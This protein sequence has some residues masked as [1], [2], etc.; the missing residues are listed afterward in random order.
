MVHIHKVSSARTR[1]WADGP[2]I[3]R[4]VHNSIDRTTQAIA[5]KEAA[6]SS[7]AV[8]MCGLFR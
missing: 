8:V 7:A 1:S 5:K 2:I 4:H 6:E 3:R